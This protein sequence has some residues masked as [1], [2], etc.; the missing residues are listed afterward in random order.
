MLAVQEGL[1]VTN[2]VGNNLYEQ[3]VSMLSMRFSAHGRL[4]VIDRETFM[5]LN[6]N[7]KSSAVSI[8]YEYEVQI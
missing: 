7:T 4:K 2:L 3:H 6:Q 1:Y 8:S 5:Q